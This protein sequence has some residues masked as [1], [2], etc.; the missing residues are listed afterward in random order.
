MRAVSCLQGELSVVDLPAPRPAAGQLLL[1]VLR[2]G[3]CGSDLHAKDHSD[4]LA[5][6][7]PELGSLDLQVDESDEPKPE[8]DSGSENP[9]RVAGRRKRAS[10]EQQNNQG[11]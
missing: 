5:D 10:K 9:P 1:D 6:A 11:D 8:G 7:I 4:E 3:I 2:C